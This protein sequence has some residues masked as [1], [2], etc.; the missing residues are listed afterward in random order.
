MPI[1]A[2]VGIPGGGAST[3]TKELSKSHL[4]SG[5]WLSEEVERSQT[6]SFPDDNYAFGLRTWLRL[7][8][9]KQLYEAQK[10]SQS[11]QVVF[12]DGYFR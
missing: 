10:L 2:F 8:R 5:F 7:L 3:L 12:V 6:F 9:V 4:S 1:V 11:G